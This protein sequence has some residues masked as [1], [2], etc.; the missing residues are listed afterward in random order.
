MKAPFVGTGIYAR[1]EHG[2]VNLLMA[3]G[4]P[5]WKNGLELRQ[6]LNPPG[7]AGSAGVHIDVIDNHRMICSVT[8][9]RSDFYPDVYLGP[10]LFKG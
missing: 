9:G 5:Y 3:S 6:W 8:Q 7:W 2:E 10:Y 1:D 4:H